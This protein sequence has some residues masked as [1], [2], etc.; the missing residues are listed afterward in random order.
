MLLFKTHV[1]WG[2]EASGLVGSKPW[3]VVCSAWFNEQ[4]NL[5]DTGDSDLNPQ[6]L[7]NH[8]FT[9]GQWLSMDDLQC[10]E[11]SVA[12]W[13][14]A[15]TD[16]RIWPDQVHVWSHDFHWHGWVQSSEKMFNVN[17][18]LCLLRKI[19][20]YDWNTP[21]HFLLLAEVF[22]CNV[23][24]YPALIRRTS[25]FSSKSSRNFN[26]EPI[27]FVTLKGL[28]MF[29]SPLGACLKRGLPVTI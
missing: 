29:K 26:C 2:E 17:I 22:I 1:F 8:T 4:R 14:A 12:A 18:K 13:R 11:M 6:Q 16:P 10:R 5:G 25:H 9:W 20:R 7:R 23:S 3:V 27:F 21:S 28:F 15:P 24:V 19:T